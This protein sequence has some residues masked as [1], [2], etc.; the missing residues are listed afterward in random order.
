MEDSLGIGDSVQIPVRVP[1]GHQ[2][3]HEPPLFVHRQ[4]GIIH[5]GPK[6]LPANFLCHEI[7]LLFIAEAVLLL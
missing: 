6:L 2:I 5:Q 4:G 7:F 1:F 3:G